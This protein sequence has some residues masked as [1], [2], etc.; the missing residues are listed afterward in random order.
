MPLEMP[1]LREQHRLLKWTG[2]ESNNK[3]ILSSKVKVLIATELS[4]SQRH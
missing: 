4:A 3:M 2:R 1:F